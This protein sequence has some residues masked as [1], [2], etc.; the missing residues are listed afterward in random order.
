[1]SLDAV[2]AGEPFDRRRG[3][4]DREQQRSDLVMQVA[5]EIGALFRLQCQQ[6]LVQPAVLRRHRGEPLG[7]EIE[8]VRQ[9]RQLGRT[10][11][12]HP[13]VIVALADLLERGR[14]VLERPQSTPDHGAD[15]QCAQQRESRE[16]QHGITRFRPDLADLVD[17]IGLQHD[18]AAAVARRW[19]RKREP[20][21]VRRR[22]GGGTSREPAASERTARIRR[23]ADPAHPAASR[24]HGGC[25]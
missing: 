22:S 7:H 11:F 9:A 6:P 25:R 3:H 2:A 24:A 5:R 18:G 16:H 13:A 1:M 21:R 23:P 19:N 4:V 17:R 10:V 8:A 20:R 15:Q 12:R 14:Q